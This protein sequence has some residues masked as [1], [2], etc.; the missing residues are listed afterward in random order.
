VQRLPPA[1]TRLKLT[2]VDFPRPSRRAKRGRWIERC[3]PK[4][5]VVLIQ[6]ALRLVGP[7]FLGHMKNK[8]GLADFLAKIDKG[9]RKLCEHFQQIPGSAGVKNALGSTHR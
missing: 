8:S 4:A 7:E 9:L 3:P 1:V 5:K 2:A 6:F